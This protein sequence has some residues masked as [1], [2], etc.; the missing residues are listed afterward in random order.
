[1][2]HIQLLHGNVVMQEDK[3]VDTAKKQYFKKAVTTFF[4]NIMDKWTKNVVLH[5]I[6]IWWLNCSDRLL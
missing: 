4:M 6:L 2:L 5:M 3:K 1:M